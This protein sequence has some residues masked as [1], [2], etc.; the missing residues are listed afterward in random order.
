MTVLLV[1]LTAIYN[2]FYK[3]LPVGI[4][5]FLTS[6]LQQPGTASY[7]ATILLGSKPSYSLFKL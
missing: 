2:H 7:Y 1:V 5:T 4:L 6:F 3:L